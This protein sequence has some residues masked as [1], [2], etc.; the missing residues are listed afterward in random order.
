MEELEKLFQ[1]IKTSQELFFEKLEEILKKELFFIKDV[2]THKTS[3][4]F[5]LD[6]IY[7]IRISELYILLLDGYSTVTIYTIEE[8]LIYLKIR[9]TV[10]E[11]ED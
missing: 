10:C 6:K 1:D 9:Q 3:M 2:I 11:L 5:K 8:L 4:S 7:I